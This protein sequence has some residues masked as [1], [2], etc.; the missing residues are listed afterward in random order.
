MPIFFLYPSN[1]ALCLAPEAKR[2]PV[3]RAALRRCDINA[4]RGFCGPHIPG[5]TFRYRFRVWEHCVLAVPSLQTVVVSSEFATP[6]P[7]G[8]K[9]RTDV[10][11]AAFGMVTDIRLGQGS[12]LFPDDVLP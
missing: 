4:A 2:G 11:G 12:P 3:A 10:R 9:P 5:T 1:H 6:N 7:H 8:G